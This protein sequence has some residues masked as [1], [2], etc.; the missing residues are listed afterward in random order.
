MQPSAGADGV[1]NGL[2][3]IER[4]AAAAAAATAEGGRA[5]SASDQLSAFSRAAATPLSFTLRPVLDVSGGKVLS[6][7]ALSV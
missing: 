4:P 7:L 3:G 1:V 5:L 6:S 2:C